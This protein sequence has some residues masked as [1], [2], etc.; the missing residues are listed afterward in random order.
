MR[1]DIAD[2]KVDLRSVRDKLDSTAERLDTKID[3]VAVRLDS[4]IEAV[5]ERLDKK[6]DGFYAKLD[7]KID[8]VKDSIWRAE[9]RL[10]LLYV[11]LAGGMLGV[12]AHGFGWL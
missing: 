8:G 6:I 10:F 9:I 4:K 7:A 5:A 11:A 1:T 3:I 12:M 2:I